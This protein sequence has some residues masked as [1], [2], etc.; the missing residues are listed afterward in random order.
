M[1]GFR[2]LTSSTRHFRSVNVYYWYYVFERPRSI[3]CAFVFGA[4]F[5]IWTSLNRGVGIFCSGAFERSFDSKVCE[6]G[7]LH[8]LTENR[9]LVIPGYPLCTF[10]C[11]VGCYGSSNSGAYTTFPPR[12][13]PLLSSARGGV[14]GTQILV[15]EGSAWKNQPR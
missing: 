12:S 1:P 8:I 13:F 3:C 7:S 5:H 4:V 6:S 2:G 11:L 10:Q 15:L 9:R 14:I